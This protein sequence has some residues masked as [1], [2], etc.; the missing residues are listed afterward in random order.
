MSIATDNFNDT[1]DQAKRDSAGF[2]SDLDGLKKSFSQLRTDLTQLIDRALVAGKSGAHTAVGGV[3]DAVGGVKD[4]VGGA[5]TGLK[6]KSI[7]S[8]KAVEE[9][10]AEHPIA[11]T[12]IAFCVGYLLGKLFSRR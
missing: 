11:A 12:A 1:A 4:A 2:A 10:I 7:D 5:A 6:E 3:K 9:H 8:A